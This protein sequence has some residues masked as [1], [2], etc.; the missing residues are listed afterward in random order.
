MDDYVNHIYYQDRIEEGF[1]KR[2]P[3][4]LFF[5]SKQGYYAINDQVL[6]S[7]T[8][9]EYSAKASEYTITVADALF[10]AVT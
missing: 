9:S 7:L 1:A 8:S 4:R 10:S 2:Y 3:S 5:L 6:R